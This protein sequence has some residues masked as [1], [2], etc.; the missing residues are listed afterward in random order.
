MGCM[1]SI[2]LGT[3]DPAR[4]A[5]LSGSDWPQIQRGEG[6]PYILAK[7]W[8][9]G[10]AAVCSVLIGLISELAAHR[11]VFQTPKERW[12]IVAAS[13]ILLFTVGLTVALAIRQRRRVPRLTEQ[14]TAAYC[15]ALSGSVINPK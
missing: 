14:V 5:R 1:G 2:R 13:A 8:Q 15:H 12:A 3:P 10:I 9:S 11:F 7:V 4:R 6:R